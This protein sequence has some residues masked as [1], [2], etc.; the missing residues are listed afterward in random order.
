[1]E[2][3]KR[4]FRAFLNSKQI[5]SRFQLPSA[6]TLKNYALVMALIALVTSCYGMASTVSLSLTAGASGPAIVLR[7][8]A[9]GLA[10]IFVLTLISLMILFI[11]G[12]YYPIVM[13][14]ARAVVRFINWAPGA[15]YRFC[16]RVQAVFRFIIAL[17][18]II[19][20]GAARFF[21]AIGRAINWLVG[22]PAWWR[23]LN[24]KEKAS[25]FFSIGFSAVYV[26]TFIVIYPL[27]HRLSL[28]A[29]SWLPMS[30]IPL[31]Q[32]LML[33]LFIGA[34]SASLL[35]TLLSFAI[36]ALRIYFK[37]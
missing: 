36:S 6:K 15:W 19:Y 5:S 24:G 25:V 26:G 7:A 32:T 9:A 33:D 37:R 35:V 13:D 27:A 20:D 28:A 3:F 2:N 23:S 16:Y 18:M 4:L 17:P 14:I 12:L 30:D 11:W 21:K 8:L 29:P 1:M 31:L 10:N 22:R 34:L